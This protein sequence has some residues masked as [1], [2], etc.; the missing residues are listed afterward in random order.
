MSDE[1][2]TS[3]NEPNNETTSENELAEIQHELETIQSLITESLK[4]L[5]NL[6]YVLSS[7][8]QSIAALPV[9]IMSLQPRQRTAF[10]AFMRRFSIGELTLE[11]FMFHLRQYVYE[12]RCVNSAYE[13][14]LN[15]FLRSLFNFPESQVTSK[16]TEI[17]S[18]IADYI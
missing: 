5:D 16:Y 9:N 2:N 7:E 14:Q 8:Y 12:E 13:I 3:K 15:P 6:D 17:V 4:Q 1:L 10:I 11:L 18:R